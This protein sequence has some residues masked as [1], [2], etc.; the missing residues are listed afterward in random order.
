MKQLL[1]A[2]GALLVM[3]GVGHGPNMPPDPWDGLHTQVSQSDA[4][5]PDC[6]CQLPGCEPCPW[7]R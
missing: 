3:A 7:V 5:A 4:P 2:T 1:L 6:G